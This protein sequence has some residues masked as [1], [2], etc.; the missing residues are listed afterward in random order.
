MSIISFILKITNKFFLIFIEFIS[1][2][3]RNWKKFDTESIKPGQRLLVIRHGGIGDLLFITPILKEIKFRYPELKITLMT[4]VTYHSLFSKYPY[5][6]RLINHAWPNVFTL[7]THD[8]ILFFDKSIEVDPDAEKMNVYDLFSIKYAKVKLYDSEKRPVIRLIDKKEYILKEFPFIL[9][10]K[11]N[12]GIQI[13]AGSPVRTPSP[14]FWKRLIQNLAEVVPNCRIFLIDKGASEISEN[15]K[16]EIHKKRGNLEIICTARQ[17]RDLQDLMNIVAFMRLIIAPDSSVIH[18]AAGLGIPSIGI[19][20]PFPSSLRVKYYP[21]TIGIDAPSKCAPCF[22]H[23]HKPCKMAKNYNYSPCFE[24][25]D[26][27][28]V[29][30]KALYLLEHH[31]IDNIYNFY[32]KGIYVESET[33]KFRNEILMIISDVIKEDLELLNGIELGSGGDPLVDSSVC[34]DLKIPYTKCGEKP[35]HLKGDARNLVWFNDNSLDYIYSS[36]L[37]EDFDDGENKIV[38]YEWYRVLKERGYLILLLPDQ[39][40]YEQY[41]EK[42]G[43]KPNE[44]HKIKHFGPEY[45]KS[46]LKSNHFDILKIYK[47]WEKYPDEYNFM[48]IAQKV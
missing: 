31:S 3:F 40:R 21:K 32:S 35:I 13:K 28:Y 7:L 6:D 14:E 43:K 15:I 24:D 26:Y 48:I 47:F 46:L 9:D 10:G 23:G 39:K 17:S 11:I 38:L 25:I 27:H 1:V 2:H 41:C 30:E 22:T 42:I 16:R 18:I 44:H 8:Y 19:Y 4:R 37:F 5:I 33:S 34:V 36:H 29:I 45:M 12:I 20:G